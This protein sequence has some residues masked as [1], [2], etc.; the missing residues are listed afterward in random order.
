MI[1]EYN[2]SVI[3]TY[4]G[5]AFAITGIYFSM[6]NLYNFAFLS[7]IVCGICDLFDGVIARKCKRTQRAKDFGVQLDSLADCILFLAFPCVI[8]FAVLGNLGFIGILY[9]I[10]GVI[11]LAWFNIS[12]NDENS[13]KFFQG[14]PVT[15]SALILPVYYL[16]HRL[17]PNILKLEYIT[18]LFVVMTIAFVADVK[19]PK[20]KGVFY[21]VLSLI[22]VITA[23]GILI[24]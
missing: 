14:L 5:I 22:A 8:A 11:R 21:I 6:Q 15:Y 4:V 17:L 16:L 9:A 1:G 20:P 23:L 19:I 13:S 12:T 7:L 18:I 24:V 10:A 3:L 2:K